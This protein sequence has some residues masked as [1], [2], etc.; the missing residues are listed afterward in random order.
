MFISSVGRQLSTLL[1][2]RTVHRCHMASD[3]AGGVVS[4]LGRPSHGG[5]TPRQLWSLS[6]SRFR[7]SVRSEAPGFV[8]S[9]RPPRRLLRWD[10]RPHSFRCYNSRRDPVPVQQRVVRLPARTT[11]SYSTDRREP[12]ARALAV[13]T[14]SSPVNP[15]FAPWGSE[16]EEIGSYVL[17]HPHDLLVNG[18]SCEADMIVGFTRLTVLSKSSLCCH[19][20]SFH[21]VRRGVCSGS[22]E[23]YHISVRSPARHAQKAVGGPPRVLRV[24]SRP[25]IWSS[26]PYRGAGT[27]MRNAFSPPAYRNFHRRDSARG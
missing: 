4:P 16:R 5:L 13:V 25:G 20:P 12:V 10:H 18:H 24:A 8:L 9:T 17:V 7:T 26:L 3:R 19:F 14:Y 22:R 23:V 2:S 27:E 6:N 1:A 15:R 11:C 21:L